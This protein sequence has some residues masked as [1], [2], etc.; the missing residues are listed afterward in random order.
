M[1][2]ANLLVFVYSMKTNIILSSVTF[3]TAVFMTG[4]GNDDNHQSENQSMS[5]QEKD[6]GEIDGKK[7][8]LFTLSNNQGMTVKITNYGGTIIAIEVPDRDGKTGDV[9]LGFDTLAEYQEKSPYFGCITGR[10][11]NR[12]AKGKFS[13]DGTEYTLATNNDTNHLHGGEKGFNQQVWNAETGPGNKLTLTWISPDGDEGYPG[14]LST[15]VT[16]AL[17]DDNGLQIDY[18]ATTDKPTVLNLTNHAY[19]NL[20]GHGEG[21]ILDHLVEIKAERYTPTDNTGIPLGAIAPVEGTPFDF[22]KATAV[23]ARIGEDDQQLKNGIGYDHNFVFKNS[24]DGKL[25]HVATVSEPKSGRI[26]EVHTSEPGLQ[27]YTG[28]YLDNLKGKAGKTYLHRG[29]LCLEAQTFPDSPNHENFP[30]PVLRPGET[31]RQTTIYRFDTS[32]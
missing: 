10:Y 6:F 23:G 11:A 13:L 29:A 27:F 22:R 1:I 7:V 19:F 12:I 17:N 15:S 20:K 16:Y 5:I 8:K 3:M 2:A 31:Y 18:K 4:C 28:N 24:R 9:C 32:K 26:L 14:T 25:Q 30:S 21:T